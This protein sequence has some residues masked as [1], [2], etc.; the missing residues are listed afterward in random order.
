MKENQYDLVLM[1]IQMPVMDGIEAVKALR[2]F[3][4]ESRPEFRQRIIGKV[5]ESSFVRL[6][7]LNCFVM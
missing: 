6:E 4:L 5:C 2:A 1:D 7:T 3:E